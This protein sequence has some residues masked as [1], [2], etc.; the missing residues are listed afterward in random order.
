MISLN[1]GQGKGFYFETSTPEL[2]V[3]SADSIV[4]SVFLFNNHHM[5]CTYQSGTWPQWETEK[6]ANVY[7]E[8]DFWKRVF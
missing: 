7:L 6:E 2:L 8:S 5:R 1:Y 4:S 3:N